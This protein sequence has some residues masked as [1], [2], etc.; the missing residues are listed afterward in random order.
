MKKGS[1]IERARQFELARDRT[2]T[3]AEQIAKRDLL[4]KQKLGKEQM[5]W[6]TNLLSV[7]QDNV[8]DQLKHDQGFRMFVEKLFTNDDH[9]VQFSDG[10]GICGFAPKRVQ[11]S[12]SINSTRILDTH[13]I[14][15]QVLVPS[16][17][18]VYVLDLYKE[19]EPEQKNSDKSPYSDRPTLALA[20]LYEPFNAPT[21]A[22][23][24]ASN[25]IL[26]ESTVN[27]FKVTEY[28]PR[29]TVPTDRKFV[30]ILKKLSSPKSTFDFFLKRYGHPV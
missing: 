30:D 11:W 7:A 19:N 28:S 8:R 12:E 6:L 17:Q 3:L 26:V 29:T 1:F 18:R 15:E 2:K 9:C 10:T 25:L 16:D 14:F 23:V 13:T 20:T 24:M 4:A 22:Q 21:I 27:H 5:R